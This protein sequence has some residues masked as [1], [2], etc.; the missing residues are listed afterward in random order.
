ME[1]ARE[2]LERVLQLDPANDPAHC[3]MAY[4][5]LRH[6]PYADDGLVQR[7]GAAEAER[8][9]ILAAVLHGGL[10]PTSKAPFARIC[11]PKACVQDFPHHDEEAKALRAE[12]EAKSQA[13]LWDGPTGLRLR[14]VSDRTGGIRGLPFGHSARIAGTDLV[15][16]YFPND[17]AVRLGLQPT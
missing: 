13:I 9:D 2:A 17:L 11:S 12:W 8:D 10:T 15:L 3:A 6:G 16:E 4:L 5:T 1:G 7:L 14:A